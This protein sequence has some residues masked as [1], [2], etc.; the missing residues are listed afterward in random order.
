MKKT[1]TICKPGCLFYHSHV[2]MLIDNLSPA[3]EFIQET[4]SPIVSVVFLNEWGDRQVIP[5]QR[6][7]TNLSGSP[8][9]GP[10]PRTNGGEHYAIVVSE[11]KLRSYLL[12]G[13]QKIESTSPP[14]IQD[15]A[16]LQS[17]YFTCNGECMYTGW[18]VRIK[19]RYFKFLPRYKL[20][21]EYNYVLLVRNRRYVSSVIICEPDLML[22]MLRKLHAV[23]YCEP[24][25]ILLTLRKLQRH[26]VN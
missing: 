2:M 10:S 26:I 8:V 14:L 9:D 20:L 25:L 16:L 12:P 23:S 11:D 17:D 5:F 15:S 21:L 22:L 6:R 18:G 13:C 4:K 24:A 7:R 1:C 19:L 3:S